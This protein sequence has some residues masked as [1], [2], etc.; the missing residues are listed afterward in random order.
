MDD[1]SRS[2]RFWIRR[3]R[4][5]R[6]GP[7]REREGVCYVEGIRQVLAAREGG[8]SFE[9]LL[10]DPQRLRSTAAWRAVTDLRSTDTPIVELSTTEFER[11]SARDNPVGIAAIVR[12][13]PGSLADLTPDPHGV[14]VVTV[15]LSDAGNLGTL[16]RTGEDVSAADPIQAVE[17]LDGRPLLLISGGLDDSIGPN[18]ADDMLAAAQ[19]A[20]VPAELQVCSTAR[21]AA[22]VEACPEDYAGWVLGFLDRVLAPTG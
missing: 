10:I 22:S 6:D 9:A 1:A 19:E 20:G 15:D 3:V 4:S 18:D 7:L 8:H 17:R 21:H 16:M 2:N 13:K 12:W 11:I 5:L 14:F